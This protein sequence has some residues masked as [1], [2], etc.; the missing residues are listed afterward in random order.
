M[1]DLTQIVTRLDEVSWF[2]DR[3]LLTDGQI[4]AERESGLKGQTELNALLFPALRKVYASRPERSGA[5]S[6]TAAPWTWG[7]GSLP[8]PWG[9]CWRRSR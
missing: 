6:W 3:D 8:S 2:R 5:Y 4:W 7:R 9:C 1:V